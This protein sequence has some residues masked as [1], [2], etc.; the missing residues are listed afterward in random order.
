MRTELESDSLVSTVLR[1]RSIFIGPGSG[2]KIR[3]LIRLLLSTSG[4]PDPV[5]SRIR[6]TQKDRIRIRNTGF[7]PSELDPVNAQSVLY[8]L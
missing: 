2:F 4:H 8:K 5:F 6:V 1:I 3:I 7:R